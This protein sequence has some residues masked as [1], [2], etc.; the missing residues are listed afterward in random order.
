DTPLAGTALR[1]VSRRCRSEVPSQA[2]SSSLR[3]R[4]QKLLRARRERRRSARQQANLASEDGDVARSCDGERLPDELDADVVWLGLG[5]F[6]HPNLDRAHRR[7]D[8]GLVIA[9]QEVRR[10]I[11]V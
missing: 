9:A 10:H 2:R 7:E 6:A 4:Y 11:T 1:R 8:G 5:E 3:T